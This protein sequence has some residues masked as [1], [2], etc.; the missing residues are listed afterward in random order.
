VELERGGEKMGVVYEYFKTLFP[1]SPGELQKT[2]H[3][4]I[5]HD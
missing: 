4:R 3:A 1:Y 5:K 2:K